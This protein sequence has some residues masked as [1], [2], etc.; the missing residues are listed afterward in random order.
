MDYER[1]LIL[2]KKEKIRKLF[3]KGILISKEVL[4]Q[5]FDNDILDM[6]VESIT[7]HNDKIVVL[8][9]QSF[10]LSPVQEITSGGD[11]D[12]P[13]YYGQKDRPGNERFFFDDCEVVISYQNNPKKYTVNDFT[14]IFSS[15]YRFLERLL[16]TGNELTSLSSISKI[17]AKKERESC[18]IIGMVTALAE[19]KSK[20]YIITLEDPTG[21]INVIIS[22]NKKELIQQ[23]R[24]IVHD[25]VIGVNGTNSDNAIF[26]DALVF[27][28]IPHKELKT[29]DE[30][31]YAV[32]LSDIHVGSTYFLADE[33]NK[34]L[35]WI[36]GEMG[37][38]E[39]QRIARNV[40]YMFITGDVVDG[41]GVY[42]G[43]EKELT[44]VDIRQQY[45][46]F[47]RLLSKVP[48][49]IRII[50][51][52]GNH[53]TVHLAE[54]QPAFDSVF[55]R[56]LSDLNNVLLV[57]NP[58]LI[59]I[60]KKEN[61]P[62]FDVLMYHGYS[63]D[64]Y[65]AHVDSLRMAGG[66]KRGDLIM[67]FLLKRRHL[68]PAFTSTPYL[69]AHDED[70]LLIKRIPDFF[71]TG[72]I[73]YSIVGNYKNTTL[74]SGSCWQACTSFQEKL[75]HEPEPARVPVVNLKTR[76]VK[77]MKFI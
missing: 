74:I 44:I 10:H 66:Y 45:E 59:T 40:K 60:C 12:S 20:N 50:I 17:L 24:D 51:C 1:S 52:P 73:H 21:K 33:F 57:S 70:P 77:V 31:V 27:P 22:K 18:S 47:A 64:H 53:D 7:K 48:S 32:F 54:P 38:D 35:R 46:E 9:K 19:T 14:T 62:G 13:D 37:N 3:D 8:T 11:D 5:E 43:Q 58:A 39:Q 49:H 76:K 72:H 67:K 16:R 63:F 55:A 61:F 29:C 25:E 23:A 42:P 26:A 30:E 28:D 71:V 69:P 41:I 6:H 56:V 34:F 68:A 65:V 15:R 2:K 4:L 36:N 75:G